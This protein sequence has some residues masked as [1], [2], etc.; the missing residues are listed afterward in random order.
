MTYREYWLR[1]R[2]KQI[3]K[4]IAIERSVNAARLSDKLTM[5][6]GGVS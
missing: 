2:S 4:T 1:P 6:C 3:E 5:G